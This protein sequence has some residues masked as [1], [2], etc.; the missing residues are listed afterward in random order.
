MN[1]DYTEYKFL[2][3]E[4]RPWHKSYGDLVKTTLRIKG[5]VGLNSLWSGRLHL[6]F[7]TWTLLQRWFDPPD[8]FDRKRRR[9][10]T[11]KGT[12][13]NREWIEQP[14][15]VKAIFFDHFSNHFQQPNGIPPLFDT[16][17]FNP[18]S[19][20]QRDSLETPFTHVEI[21]KVVW[22]CGGDHAQGPDGF[23]F[24]FFTTFWDLIEEGVIRFVRRNILDVPL[25][26]NE[27]LAWYHRR[28]KALMVFKVDFEKA[29]DSIRW[30]YLDLVLDKPGFGFKWRS[31]ILGCL[32]NA[33]SSVLLTVLPPLRLHVFTSKAEEIG[34][35]IGASIG[36]DN[37][38]LSHLM[39]ADDVI[40]LGEWSWLNAHHLMCMLRCFFLISG[41]KVNVH[42]SNVLGVG[43]S[44]NDVS[45]MAN[46]IGCGA[47]IIATCPG[48]QIGIISSK[49]SLLRFLLGKLGFYRVSLVDWNLV[50][51]REPRGGSESAQ[52]NALKDAIGN[53][54]LSDKRDS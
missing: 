47:N 17:A 45:C 2:Q 11:I 52:L 1:P 53:V 8:E 18:L 30:D 39:Y 13:K 46:I 50:L 51:R 23:T 35:F 9:Q 3:I 48:A 15:D 26:L 20:S 28:K 49:S 27:V 44:D 42:K 25:I 37:M 31:W 16:A 36:H 12:L 38:K 7:M 22:D 54:W 14:D 33:R 41:L 6:S 19:S 24:K 34:L 4:A 29:F 43:V 5:M 40:F 10:L 32:K 21:K